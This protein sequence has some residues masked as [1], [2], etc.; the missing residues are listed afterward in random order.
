MAQG[1]QLQ[2]NSFSGA[3]ADNLN[4]TLKGVVAN[5]GQLVT[6]TATD[7]IVSALGALATATLG[8]NIGTTTS[9]AFTNATVGTA[10]V[11]IVAANSTRINIAFISPNPAAAN[12]WIVPSTTTAV[13]GQG[14]LILPGGSVEFPSTCGWNAIATSGSS[15]MLTVLEWK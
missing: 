2:D 6:N 15:N 14:V 4:S 8:A 9:P 1:D 3:G 10:S 11:L 13:A 12:M 7:G 5:L